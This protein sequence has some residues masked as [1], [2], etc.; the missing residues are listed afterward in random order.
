M[1]NARIFEHI[2]VIYPSCTIVTY[3]NSPYILNPIGSYFFGSSLMY[4]YTHTYTHSH[5]QL[6][7]LF[8]SSGRIGQ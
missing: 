8:F 6:F 1:N 4:M 2:D 7:W 3:F 5:T